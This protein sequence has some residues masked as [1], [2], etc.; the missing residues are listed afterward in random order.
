MNLLHASYANDETKK[1]IKKHIRKILK[2]NFTGGFTPQ[3]FLFASEGSKAHIEFF[4]V[5]FEPILAENT[6]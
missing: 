5:F 3:H 2:M 1:Q 6:I 4:W